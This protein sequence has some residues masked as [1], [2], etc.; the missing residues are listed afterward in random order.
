MNELLNVKWFVYKSLLNS[1]AI[2]AIF[3]LDAIVK[4][5]DNSS[6]YWTFV[7]ASLMQ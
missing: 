3:K 2:N 5:F 6:L 1:K 4:W 7:L